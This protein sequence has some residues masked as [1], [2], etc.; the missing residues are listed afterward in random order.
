MKIAMLSA[1]L[2]SVMLSACGGDALVGTWV[3]STDPNAVTDGSV[4]FRQTLVINSGAAKT[5]SQTTAIGLGTATPGCI[6][7]TI[8][9]GTYAD[10]S[11]SITLKLTA[12]TSTTSDCQDTQGNSTT[13]LTT[14][15]LGAI[16]NITSTYTIS[17]S[18]LTVNVPAIS[19]E[20]LPASTYIYTKQ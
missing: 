9:S 19:L 18:K 3:S 7:T 6:S 20:G 16:G 2:A 8:V 13:T 11:T 12:G 5:F 14:S 1:A 4:S 17:G 10:T 15:Q